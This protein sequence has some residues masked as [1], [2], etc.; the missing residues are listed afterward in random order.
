MHQILDN[1]TK[2]PLPIVGIKA[3]KPPDSI[4]V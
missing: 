1:G 3:E 2:I 4:L